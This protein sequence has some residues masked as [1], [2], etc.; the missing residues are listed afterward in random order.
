[1]EVAPAPQLA[2]EISTLAEIALRLDQLIAV[3]QHD[4]QVPERRSDFDPVPQ[5]PAQSQC[6]PKQT[7]GP[8]QIAAKRPQ[9]SRRI[10]SLS[11]RCQIAEAN[12]FAGLSRRGEL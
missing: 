6:I 4:P 5:I 1:M 7:I 12:G 9:P 8:G 11:S 3:H 2:H 10:E